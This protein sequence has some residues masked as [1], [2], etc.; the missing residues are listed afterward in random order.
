MEV[1]NALDENGYDFLP[2]LPLGSFISCIE[3]NDGKEHND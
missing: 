1:F 2:Q 3:R